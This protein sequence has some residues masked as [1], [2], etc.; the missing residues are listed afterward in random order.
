MKNKPRP[1]KCKFCGEKFQPERPLQPCCTIKCAIALTHKQHDDKNKRDKIERDRLKTKQLRPRNNWFARLQILV[2]QWVRY[3]D[4]LEPCCTCGTTNQ[5]IKYDAGHFHTKKA[6]P[7]IRFEL[8]NIHKQ[9]SVKCN[10]HGSGMR[11]EYS[12]FIVEKYGKD[13]LDWLNS[14]QPSLKEVFP[15]WQDIENEIKKY[16]LFLRSVGVKPNI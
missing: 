6:R 11:K 7:D 14:P 2:N 12:E 8:T 4:R 1:K 3:R 9:C 15:N 10:Q 16:R 5:N 13:H